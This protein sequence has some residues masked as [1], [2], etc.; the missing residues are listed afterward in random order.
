[1]AFFEK[2]SKESSELK[3]SLVAERLFKHPAAAREDRLIEFLR[4][5]ELSAIEAE[6]I[7]SNQGIAY[8]AAA[9]LY[10][11]PL[12]FEEKVAAGL[13]GMVACLQRYKPEKGNFGPYAKHW[14]ERAIKDQQGEA[15][16]IPRHAMNRLRQYHRAKKALMLRTSRSD[17][18]FDEIVKEMGIKRRDAIANLHA[19]LE[20]TRPIEIDDQIRGSTFLSQ[21]GGGNNHTEQE[22]ITVVVKAVEDQALDKAL[23]DQLADLV[24]GEE[25]GFKEREKEVLLWRLGLGGRD[26]L[27]RPEVAELFGMTR[28]GIRQIEIRTLPKLL[29]HPR[30][31]DAFPGL[32][33]MSSFLGKK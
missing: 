17:I 8:R 20:L 24:C 15:L 25:L 13:D 18:S 6:L 7:R 12:T 10:T 29:E 21:D 22:R 28:E 33:W 23:N 3:P 16:G 11:P 1:M 5:F 26:Q 27:S 19:I 32:D 30:L 31:K 4:A 2:M 14:V 9:Q